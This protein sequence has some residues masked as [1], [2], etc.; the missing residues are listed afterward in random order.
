MKWIAS[1]IKQFVSDDG[2]PSH[3]GSPYLSICSCV[4]SWPLYNS[5]MDGRMQQSSH[6]KTRKH[7]PKLVTCNHL[8]NLI[9]ATDP[10][11]MLFIFLSSNLPELQIIC[12]MVKIIHRFSHT[13]LY[14]YQ[15]S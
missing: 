5:C 14:F 9:S 6:I 13:H 15:L 2:K 1:C 7:L 4:H 11:A 8:V 3:H 10:K 12:I